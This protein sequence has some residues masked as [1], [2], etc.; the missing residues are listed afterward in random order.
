MHCTGTAEGSDRGLAAEP[1][2]AAFDGIFAVVSGHPKHKLGPEL[3]SFEASKLAGIQRVAETHAEYAPHRAALQSR[4][5][6][7][8]L[9]GHVVGK[10]DRHSLRWLREEQVP[11]MQ[12][13]LADVVAEQGAL[14]TECPSMQAVLDDVMAKV[15]PCC[16]PVWRLSK[17]RVST[18]SHL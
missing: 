11:K 15:R 18:V 13:R 3:A 10:M 9:W 2:L 6:V 7:S 16:L 5:G 17:G 8:A 14:P 4:L 12:L 1:C